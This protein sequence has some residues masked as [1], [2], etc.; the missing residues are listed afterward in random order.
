MLRHIAKSCALSVVLGFLALATANHGSIGW[1]QQGWTKVSC[2]PPPAQ[3]RTY[4]TFKFDKSEVGPIYA[5]PAWLPD[6]QSL[7]FVFLDAIIIYRVS[8]GQTRFIVKGDREGG[9]SLAVSPDGQL[10]AVGGIDSSKW[11]GTVSI[12]R[13]EDGT[14]VF[15]LK[16]HT[17]W[18]HAVAFSPDGQLLASG[19]SPKDHSVKIWKVADGSLV[20]TMEHR[21]GYAV[22]ALAFSPDGQLL[23]SGGVDRT[24]NI[25]RVADGSLVRSIEQPR[26]VLTVD[27]SPDG[28]LIA[29]GG[30]PDRSVKLWRVSDGSLVRLFD[31]PSALGFI[32]SVDFSPDGQW[33]AS[34]SRNY[35]A[36]L[37]RVADGSLLETLREDH[38]RDVATVR[39]SPGGE[40]LMVESVWFDHIIHLWRL[41]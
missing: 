26:E 40:W 32:W 20:H 34:G 23:A 2:P 25:W 33:L 4:C 30:F 12:W 14:A 24:L 17:G 18:V 39:F 11:D 31:D 28:Q 7:A 37:W 41:P 16:G 36:R 29:A 21:P 13:V 5:N 15:R 38:E 6:G 3:P 19:G 10:L 9:K 35:Q 22:R 27:F 8:D 1:S